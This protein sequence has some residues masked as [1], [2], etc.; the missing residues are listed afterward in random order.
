MTAVAVP[1]RAHADPDARAA[2]SPFRSL[3]GLRVVAWEPDLC[4]IEI[5]VRDPLKNFSGAVAGPVV[6]AAVDMAAAMAGCYTPDPQPTRRAVTLSFTVSFVAPVCEGVIRARA[7]K[8][9]G[10]RSVFTSIVTVTNEAGVTIATGQGTFRYV[11][12]REGA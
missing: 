8:A 3:L 7:V 10:G 9:G 11:S 1:R 12:Q 5:P 6:A 4:V 2:Q